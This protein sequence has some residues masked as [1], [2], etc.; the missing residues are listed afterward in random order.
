[1]VDAGADDDSLYI[2]NAAE[3]PTVKGGLGADSINLGVVSKGLVQGQGGND[4]NV[5]ELV[6]LAHRLKQVLVMT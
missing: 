5:L 1:M 2:T 3:R 4:I 6:L